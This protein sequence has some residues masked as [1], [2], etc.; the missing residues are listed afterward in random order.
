MMPRFVLALG[1]LT[2]T[3]LATETEAADRCRLYG[4]VSEFIVDPTGR[5][6]HFRFHEPLDCHKKPATPRISKAWKKTACVTFVLDRPRPTY[7]EGQEP[8]A[9]YSFWVFNADRP[10]VVT[11]PGHSGRTPQEPVIYV[12]EE[13]LEGRG[14]E[15]DGSIVCD[16]DL[17]AAAAPN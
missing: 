5:L 16:Q 8:R 1:L 14:L 17:D 4:V 13:I 6:T 7:D 15:R 10:D 3:A 2:G 12:R 9:L 11:G